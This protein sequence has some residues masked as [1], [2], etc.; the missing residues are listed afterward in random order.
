MMIK[1]TG[2]FAESFLKIFVENGFGAL[3]KRDI[4]VLVFHLLIQDGMYEFP[5][6]IFRACRELRLTEARVRNLYRAAQ[7]RYSLYDEDEAKTRFV[8]VIQKGQFEL[9]SG[10]LVFIVRDPLLRQYFEEWV[11]ACDCFTDTSFN[12]N[13]VVMSVDGFKKVVESLTVVD[14]A[15][16]K[17][18]FPVG[19]ESFSAAKTRK[20]LFRLFTEEFV[21]GAGNEAG[22]LTVRTLAGG[23]RFL[24]L[25]GM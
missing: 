5:K 13:L 1:D 23:L 16:I 8:E 11:A 4:D 14:F 15:E 9:Q 2:N 12:K 20:G 21:K 18:Q 7:L 19:L 6:D 22:A 25:G 24:I 10:K 17:G 3:G